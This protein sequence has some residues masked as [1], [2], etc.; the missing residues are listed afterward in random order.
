MCERSEDENAR[1]AKAWYKMPS[2]VSQPKMAF[3]TRLWLYEHLHFQPFSH[4]PDFSGQI[5]L[6]IEKEL[7]TWLNVIQLTTH[8]DI[9]TISYWKDKDKFLRLLAKVTKI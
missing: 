4:M 7:D 1:K 2:F 8:T 3:Y 5:S 9:D 6:P